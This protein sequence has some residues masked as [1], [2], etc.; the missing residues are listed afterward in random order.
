[1]TPTVSVIVPNYN[2]AP[3]LL[4]RI[5]SILHQ[6]YPDF[7]VILIDD[8]STD[9]SREI[10]EHYREHP[11]VSHVLFNEH[12]SGSPFLQWD[13]GIS[14]SRGKYIW[15]AE[16]DDYASPDFLKQVMEAFRHHPESVLVYTGSVLVDES[17]HP[18]KDD[19][20]KYTPHE[21]LE[22]CY[23]PVDFLRHMLWKNHVY[24]A[25]MVVFRKETYSHIGI[26]FKNFRYCGDW[27]CWIETGRQ[28]TVTA[29]N[30]KLNYF[31]QHMRKVSPYAE[32]QG[33]YF[34]EG[35][36]VMQR[37]MDYLHLTPY[38][39]HVVA[40]RTLKRLNKL[41]RKD[42]ALRRQILQ[43]GLFFA[44]GSSW[45]IFLYEVDKWFD[46]SGLQR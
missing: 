1:M 46:F 21:A 12:N 16:S 17:G 15:I 29:L 45:D 33:L 4:Q 28:G 22:T 20:D 40:G 44:S 32:K 5:D 34:L 43:K 30:R 18:L 19:W 13:K 26:D 39:R 27:L 9:N 35:G 36:Q 25:S 6:T 37:I 41:T 2:H 31:R 7:E 8:C 14:L 10:L 3:Y 11:K 38:Q 23:S 24:N 42:P